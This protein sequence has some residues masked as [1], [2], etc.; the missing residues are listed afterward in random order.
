MKNCTL[1]LR[2][3]TIMFCPAVVTLWRRVKQILFRAQEQEDLCQL[4]R[5]NH[6]LESMCRLKVI[7]MQKMFWAPRDEFLVWG[8]WWA[9]D[10]KIID[11]SH[12]KE[13]GQ[14]L[15]RNDFCK[16]STQELSRTWAALLL[17]AQCCQEVLFWP[18]PVLS[19]K[20]TQFQSTPGY[21]RLVAGFHLTSPC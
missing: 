3:R 7:M 21:K 13:K 16:C 4:N 8:S 5:I 11:L 2:I 1:S 9:F 17:L 15:C 18:D 6:A 19:N 10:S 12:W 14:L 20:S